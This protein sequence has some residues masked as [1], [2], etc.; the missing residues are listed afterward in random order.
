MEQVPKGKVPEPEDNWASA[1]MH[2]L[3][4]EV[5][6]EDVDLD[7]VLEEVDKCPDRVK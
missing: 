4:E 6:G 7:D 2:S 3:L 5:S 1:I